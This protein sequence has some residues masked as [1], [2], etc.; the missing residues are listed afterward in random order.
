MKRA[1]GNS[2]TASV[3]CLP[4]PEVSEAELR[5]RRFF[6][7]SLIVAALLAAGIRWF[8]ISFSSYDMRKYLIPWFQTLK[9]GGGFPALRQSI[10]NYSLAYLTL[11][12]LGTYVPLSPITV[13]K[14]FSIVFDYAAAAA[15]A[16]LIFVLEKSGPRVRGLC[17]AASLLVLFS[18]ETILNS[19]LWGQCDVI[20]TFFCLM[21]IAFLIQRRMGLAFCFL[22]WALAFKLQAIFFLPLFVFVWLTDRSRRLRY[23]LLIPGMMALSGLPA[24]CMGHP[25][26][27]IFGIY[28]LQIGWMR[29]MTAGCPNL[30]TFAP[31]LDFGSFASA[32]VIGTMVILALM[33]LWLLRRHRPLAPYEIVLSAVWCAM[34]CVCFLPDMHERYLFPADLLLIVPALGRKRLGDCICAI[35]SAGVSVLSYLPFLFQFT[36]V[37]MW[38]LALIR[39]GCLIFVTGELTAPHMGL[40]K[41][42]T[43]HDPSIS[44]AP[45]RVTPK[46]PG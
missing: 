9:S 27:D 18:P 43:V 37:P 32:G 31:G 45:D 8:L 25:V 16:Y 38:T 41:I 36:A 29:V 34:V 14:L 26:R 24:V 4:T 20:Y 10:G 44:S 39:L 11:L 15:C 42:N 12:A 35:S 3:L 13:I 2:T 6:V 21:S 22:G 17:K 40:R 33:L 23:F 1:Q 30:Y 46:M 19:A 28:G 7:L 5:S